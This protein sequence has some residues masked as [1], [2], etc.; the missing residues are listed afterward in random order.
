VIYIYDEQAGKTLQVSFITD[1]K[2]E[3]ARNLLFRLALSKHRNETPE[4][5]KRHPTGIFICLAGT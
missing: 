3:S 1:H 2:P 5:L 4:W